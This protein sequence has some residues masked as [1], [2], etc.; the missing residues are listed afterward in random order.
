MGS[1]CGYGRW[2]STEIHARSN[3]KSGDVACSFPPCEPSALQ[4]QSTVRKQT[5][6]LPHHSPQPNGRTSI[7]VWSTL[8][9]RADV[10]LPGDSN[11][12]RTWEV[13]ATAPPEAHF[14]ASIVGVA[15]VT[16]RKESTD[17][18]YPAPYK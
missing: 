12:A 1:S 2:T 8:D 4:S 5:P 3:C 11:A 16:P 17:D 15:K 7:D 9:D 10:F 18:S 14:F 6:Q 13:A